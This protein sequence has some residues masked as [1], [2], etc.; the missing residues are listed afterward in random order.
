[1]FKLNSFQKKK[2]TQDLTIIHA[3]ALQDHYTNLHGGLGKPQKLAPIMKKYKKTGSDSGFTTSKKEKTLEEQQNLQNSKKM[4][5]YYKKLT[6]AQRLGIIEAPPAPLS[7]EA[8]RDIENQS[9]KRISSDKEILCPI[10]LEEFKNENQI[11]LSCSHVFH[12]KCLKSFEQH[13]KIKMCPICR[14]KDYDTR[15]TDQGTKLYKEKSAIRIQKIWRGYW[16]RKV[17]FE[18]M[19]PG[20]KITSLYLRR[21]LMG[22]KLKVIG[23]RMDRKMNEK[24]KVTKNL[25]EKIEKNIM[26]NQIKIA[27]DL[28][29]L[30]HLRLVN[31]DQMRDILENG[32]TSAELAAALPLALP[33]KKKKELN[34][35]K[36]TIIKEK[37]LERC[38][39][40]CS[41]CF[42]PI[43]NKK[44][45]YLLDCTH[46]FH[47][48]CI[49][50]FERYN[51]NVRHTCP[52]CRNEYQKVQMV[53]LEK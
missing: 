52:V 12:T 11:I 19:L 36:W 26:E 34:S 10:C 49:D 25:M 48:H 6:L 39:D 24:N 35:Q 32:T 40:Q 33:E 30:S 20:R 5:N 23:M 15:L 29:S 22:Y 3:A 37:A 44:P 27:T 8:W 14:R 16:Q 53:D 45:L 47:T 28:E 18:R 2:K 51:P 4:H 41:I 38:G 17:F 21:K 13:T 7:N 42:N 31:R 46:V 1:M 43:F 50:S 9:L